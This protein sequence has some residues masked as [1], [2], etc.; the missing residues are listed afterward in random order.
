M[1]KNFINNFFKDWVVFD[2]RLD[3]KS[4][5]INISINLISQIVFTLLIL[6]SVFGSSGI[7]QVIL[8]FPAFVILGCLQINF[9]SL[10]VRRLHDNSKS[11]WW[12]LL[13]FL[14]IVFST[15]IRQSTSSEEQG[16]FIVLLIL[17]ISLFLYFLLSSN[18]K[19]KMLKK[20]SVTN[21]SLTKKPHLFKNYKILS[22]LTV[23]ILTISLFVFI[24]YKTSYYKCGR[25]G[26]ARS[27]VI[28]KY[29]PNNY[30]MIISNNKLKPF[31]IKKESC[32]SNVDSVGFMC[33]FRVPMK[34][35]IDEVFELLEIKKRALAAGDKKAVKELDEY[36]KIMPHNKYLYR[37]D[38]ITIRLKEVITSSEEG[39]ISNE[40]YQCEQT[41]NNF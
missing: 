26:E 6:N 30:S 5:L 24:P 14:S 33:K 25:F 39:E 27:L 32:H 13:F 23:I 12:I 37:F 9:Y 36:I 17:S 10:I 8:G 3:R 38:P 11:G 19:Q 29:L 31:T 16:I 4:F 28:N 21:I 34:E 1:I 35:N 20:S 40:I 18:K 41:E 15:G 7:T 22:I 2:G